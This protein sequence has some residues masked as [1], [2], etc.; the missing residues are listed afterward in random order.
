MEH[1]RG[2]L[3][4]WLDVL[5]GIGAYA[6][7]LLAPKQEVTMPNPNDP[8]LEQQ[9][10]ALG[11]EIDQLEQQIENAPEG[12]DTS[13]L[14]SQLEAKEQQMR[15]LQQQRKAARDHYRQQNPQGKSGE[16]KANAPGQQRPK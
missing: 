4:Q 14:E 1:G 7:D 16:A 10:K 3:R 13:D 9:K 8:Q 2:R 11:A 15:Q 5:V 12:Q 6:L